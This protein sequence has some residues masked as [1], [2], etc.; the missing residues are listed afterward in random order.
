MYSEVDDKV[1][2]S[3]QT[4]APSEQLC[5]LCVFRECVIL[6]GLAHKNEKYYTKTNQVVYQ[7]TAPNGI[8]NKHLYSNTDKL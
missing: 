6:E 3:S 8:Q 2:H 5:F 7:R 1:L 4:D